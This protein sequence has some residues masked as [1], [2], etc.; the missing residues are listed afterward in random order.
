MKPILTRVINRQNKIIYATL[1]T[2]LNS[3]KVDDHFQQNGE[4]YVVLGNIAIIEKR[5]RVKY[6]SVV[7]YKEWES[8]QEEMRNR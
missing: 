3:L 5:M 1:N 6:V 7:T 2:E 8:H 4:T